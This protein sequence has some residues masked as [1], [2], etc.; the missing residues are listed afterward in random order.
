MQETNFLLL[1]NTQWNVSVS[2]SHTM[3]LSGL[4]PLALY[5]YNITSCTASGTCNTTGTYI[6]NESIRTI[7]HTMITVRDGALLQRARARAGRPVGFELIESTS[8]ED[9]TVKAP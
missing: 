3:P 9:F 5:Y 1:L 7:M 8:A 2:V 4:T 6:V